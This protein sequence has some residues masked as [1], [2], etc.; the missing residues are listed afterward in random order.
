[1]CDKVD[2]HARP[3]ALRSDG[4][5]GAQSRDYPRSEPAGHTLFKL[6]KRTS[7]VTCAV[8]ALL[9]VICVFAYTVARQ[10]D[11]TYVRGGS[12]VGLTCFGLVAITLT[13][14]CGSSQVLLYIREREMLPSLLASVVGLVVLGSGDT[15]C[16]NS[17]SY[18]GF[19][20][21]AP[22]R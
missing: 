21:A 1:M 16:C 6:F 8:R 17:C 2:R 14:N 18:N 12:V 15:G 7:P 3:R 9:F 20:L 10:I 5:Q 11:R 13:V 22:P 4:P 19:L